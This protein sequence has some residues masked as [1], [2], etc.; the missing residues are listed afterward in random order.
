LN[1]DF[2][3]CV[4]NTKLGSFYLFVLLTLSV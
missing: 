4:L 3:V 1:V 2:E